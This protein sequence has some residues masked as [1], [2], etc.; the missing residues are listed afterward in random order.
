MCGGCSYGSKNIPITTGEQLLLAHHANVAPP[1]G[2]FEVAQVLPT[3]EDTPTLRSPLSSLTLLDT[4]QQKW[5]NA[6]FS[7][8]F[9]QFILVHL[10]LKMDS[11]ITHQCL[12]GSC[13]GKGPMGQG[14]SVLGAHTIT[15]W[16]MPRNYTQIEC[17]E[18]WRPLC[19]NGCAL[20]ESAR[21]NHSIA[22]SFPCSAHGLEMRYKLDR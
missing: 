18:L 8:P 17:E 6:G 20:Y 5:Y 12:P 10:W 2:E 11:L 16:V 1:P 15:E 3:D 13:G 9:R 7:Y 21:A 4:Q 22:F 19:P 14:G